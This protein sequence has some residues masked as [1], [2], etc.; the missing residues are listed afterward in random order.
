MAGFRNPFPFFFGLAAV[1]DGDEPEVVSARYGTGR[2]ERDDEPAIDWNLEYYRRKK[3]RR[4][5][6]AV[7][8]ALGV[9]R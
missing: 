4:N 9:I 3:R 5:E 8:M 6:E 1:E 2:R 7:L